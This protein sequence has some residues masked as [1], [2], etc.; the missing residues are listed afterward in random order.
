MDND[1]L[2]CRA[3]DRV[4]YGWQDGRCAVANSLPAKG[5]KAETR[6]VGSVFPKS[7]KRTTA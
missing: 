4:F 5:R 6:P 3:A 7:A 2:G 1:H